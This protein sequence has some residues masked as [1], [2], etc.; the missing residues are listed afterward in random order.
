[1]KG[2]AIIEEDSN[3][4]FGIVSDGRSISDNGEVSK[5]EPYVSTTTESR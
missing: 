4:S 5:Q 3:D 1:M 2:T